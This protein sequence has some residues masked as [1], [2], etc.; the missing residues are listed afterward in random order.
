MS[1]TSP[2]IIA[3]FQ[4]GK[5][6]KPTP[7]KRP[8]GEKPEKDTHQ[9]HGE[10]AGA[11]MPEMNHKVE[12]V[13]TPKHLAHSKEAILHTYGS[14]KGPQKE[15]PAARVK[16]SAHEA[17][18]GATESWIRGSMSSKEHDDIHRRANIALRPKT[19]G[20]Q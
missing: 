6:A 17:K 2:L 5:V 18:A 7:K 20:R 9:Q 19:K 10:I 1:K 16:R 4:P 14:H 13:R 8:K 3:A 11:S 12:G 15:S